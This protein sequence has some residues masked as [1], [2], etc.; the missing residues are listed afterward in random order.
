V[1]AEYMKTYAIGDLHGELKML[2]AMLDK[3][4]LTEDDLVVFLGDYIDRGPDARGVI[5]RILQLR[6]QG[7]KLIALKGN[8]E[9]MYLNYLRGEDADGLFLNNGG[10]STIRSYRTLCNRNGY[11]PAAHL[12]FLESLALFHEAGNDFFVHA[13]ARP[14]VALDDQAE[15]DL[16]WIRS[17]FLG[18]SFDFGKRI[19]FGHTPCRKP[20]IQ[21][22]KI[23]IDTGATYGGKLTC[24]CLPDE[25]FYTV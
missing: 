8:H 14:C 3:L 15:E 12:E 1:E 9:A 24:L 22:D 5:D 20:L 23:G 16:L 19:I 7:L 21:P 13:G 6:E 17:D 11:P 18:C 4:P 10:R 25:I 2:E